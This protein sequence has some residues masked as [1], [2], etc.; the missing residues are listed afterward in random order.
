MRLATAADEIFP[1]KDPKVQ[2]DPA[3]LTV[4]IL[5]RVITQLGSIDR[6]TPEI[7]K[8]LCDSDRAYLQGFY[9]Q[10]N[11]NYPVNISS[12]LPEM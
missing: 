3:Y 7:I 10:M 8:G 6:I 5:S 9:Q 11:G 2:A 1:M 4:I 12:N